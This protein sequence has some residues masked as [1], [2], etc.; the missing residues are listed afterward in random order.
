[1]PMVGPV[2]S[3][4][5]AAKTS[6]IKPLLSHVEGGKTVDKVTKLFQDRLKAPSSTNIHPIALGLVSDQ[7][8]M[9]YEICQV[10]SGFIGRHSEPNMP[11]ALNNF[12][13]VPKAFTT[14]YQFVK[15]S[16]EWKKKPLKL[17]ALRNLQLAQSGSYA[18]F[19]LFRASGL[20]YNVAKTFK[21]ALESKAF[22]SVATNAWASC[23]L[24]FSVFRAAISSLALVKAYKIKSLVGRTSD[25][26]AQLRKLKQEITVT[27]ADLEK[28]VKKSKKTN[29]DFFKSYYDKKIA[30]ESTSIAL[31]LGLSV[32]LDLSGFENA[33]SKKEFKDYLMSKLEL[34]S[35]LASGLTPQAFLGLVIYRLDKGKQKEEAFIKSIC[36]SKK[37]GVEIVKMLK[38]T[39][40]MQSIHAQLARPDQLDLATKELFSKIQSCANRKI[41]K[42]WVVIASC[43]LTV[44][45]IA[46]GVLC[47]PAAGLLGF[48]AALW[49]MSN[50]MEY[51]LTLREFKVASEAH[52]E[53]LKKE[54]WKLALSIATNVLVIAIGITAAVLAVGNPAGALMVTAAVVAIVLYTAFNAAVYNEKARS[55]LVKHAEWIDRV[56][57]QRFAEKIGM[58]ITYDT[59]IFDDA[60]KN[61]KKALRRQKLLNLSFERKKEL[62][63][64][65]AV[66]FSRYR[67]SK[68]IKGQAVAVK[69][70]ELEPFFRTPEGQRQLEKMIDAKLLEL[71]DQDNRALLSNYQS[72][73]KQMLK[74]SMQNLETTIK[75]A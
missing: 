24:I 43:V 15:D 12:N 62:A 2:S 67:F 73:K 36:D 22:Q 13:S 21:P 3:M 68:N 48:A 9:T 40:K 19:N 1:M 54:G 27:G 49:I 16:I 35:T 59:A 4:S 28:D 5:T 42:E 11:L 17:K 6:A 70:A 14:T 74:E 20:L 41:I 75:T 45:A 64:K 7:N 72:L 25:L 10:A 53:P 69:A 47:P 55:L 37:E 60:L 38:S 52:A 26:G 66:D 57:N 31:N 39:L 33:F 46:T 44:V 18:L 61:H 58:P 51:G 56:I 50:F 63:R 29:E 30:E 71:Y 65:L 8:S 23:L 32:P 34:D